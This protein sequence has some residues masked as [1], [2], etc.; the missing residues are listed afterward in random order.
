MTYL[1]LRVT[2]SLYTTMDGK[3]VFERT[4][5]LEQFE[6]DNILYLPAETVPTTV[7]VDTLLKAFSIT[8]ILKPTIT[9]QKD[10]Y[11]DERPYE[12][13]FELS[14]KS[15]N[16][17]LKKGNQ[18]ISAN[19]RMHPM[20]KAGITS[21]LRTLG[22][23]IPE[24]TVQPEIPFSHDKPCQVLITVYP[25]RR[26]RMDPPNWYPTIKALIDGMTDANLWEDD[27]NLTIKRFIFEYGG[28]SN[29]PNY[30]LKIRISGLTN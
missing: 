23:D 7:N 28:I 9:V 11:V 29:T 2:D 30:I 18:M 27:D 1:K 20:V 24:S 4:D 8:E 16:K 14:R 26:Y 3:P 25:P 13:V 5:A 15:G 17:P 22:K 12:Y 10:D 19:D 6:L 21:Y